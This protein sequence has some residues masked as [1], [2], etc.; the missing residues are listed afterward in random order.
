VT[1]AQAADAE[2]HSRNSKVARFSNRGT[3]HAEIPRQRLGPAKR[4]DRSMAREVPSTCAGHSVLC[5]YEDNGEGKCKT[6]ERSF[7]TLRSER[8]DRVG[9]KRASL[10]LG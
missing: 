4:N 7:P 10:R 8:K 6:S 3:R 2:I 5:P 9:Q 1:L